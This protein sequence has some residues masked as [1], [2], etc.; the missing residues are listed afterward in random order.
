MQRGEAIPGI[1]FFFDRNSPYRYIKVVLLWKVMNDDADKFLA[2]GRLIN[3]IPA[4][5]WMRVDFNLKIYHS[6]HMR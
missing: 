5:V 4:G 2:V 3:Q 1:K 6:T